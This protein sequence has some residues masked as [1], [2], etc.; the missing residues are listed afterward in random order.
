MIHHTTKHDLVTAVQNVNFSCK[1]H[2][3]CVCCRYNLTLWKGDGVELLVVV[4]TEAEAP[5]YAAALQFS[6]ATTAA[7]IPGPIL[8]FSFIMSIAARGGQQLD[9]AASA[10]GAQPQ[11]AAAVQLAFL[12]PL[13]P[14]PPAPPP[15]PPPPSP[16]ATGNLESGAAAPPHASSACIWRVAWW[17]VL[18]GLLL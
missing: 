18:A 16:S 3:W 4:Q 2:S 6:A 9:A 12:S 13:S 5:Q 14:P 8:S 1:L 11:S 15:S 17:V 7:N 10:P